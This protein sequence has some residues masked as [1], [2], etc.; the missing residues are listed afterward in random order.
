MNTIKQTSNEVFNRIE[1]KYLLTQ[2]QYE[3]IMTVLK[4][5]M[6][7]DQNSQEN[8]CYTISNIYYDTVD[9]QLIS[10][11]IEKPVYKEK[12]RLRAYGQPT[13]QSKVYLEIKKKYKGQGNKR[14]CAL[15]LEEAYRFIET[16]QM[17]PPKPYHNFQVLKELQYFLTQYDLRP[18]VFIAYDRVALSADQLRITFDHNIRTRRIGVDLELGQNGELLLPEDS[19]LMEVKAQESFPLWLVKAFS[20]QKI[21][22]TSFSKYGKEFETCIKKEIKVYV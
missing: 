17:P 7:S 11:S 19:W 5:H 20:E 3:A 1:K 4:Q 10:K 15:T 22:A 9:H 2:R 8:A 14:R 12:L 6:T 13:L 21:Y 18:A 16:K